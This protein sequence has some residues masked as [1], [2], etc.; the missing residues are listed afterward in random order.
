M[1][2][3]QS[4][5]KV[6]EMVKELLETNPKTRTSDDVLYYEVCNRIVPI[7]DTSAT[8]LLLNRARLNLPPYESV[9]RT[10]QKIQEAFPWLKNPVTDSYRMAE[11]TEVRGVLNGK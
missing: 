1:G 9:R 4:M 10:R 7:A 2:I 3:A 6:K 5:V 8:D 11:E